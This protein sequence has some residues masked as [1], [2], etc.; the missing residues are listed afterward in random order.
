MFDYE[1]GDHYYWSK[2]R[3][4]LLQFVLTI[5]SNVMSNIIHSINNIIKINDESCYHHS[6]F[7]HDHVHLT[8][9]RE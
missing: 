7:H 4:E 8:V 6:M 2:C 1:G 3:S 9:T 5:V